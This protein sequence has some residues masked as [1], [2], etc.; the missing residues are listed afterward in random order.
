[1]TIRLEDIDTRD[2]IRKLNI[3]II[4]FQLI[5]SEITPALVMFA[6]P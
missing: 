4:N 5:F 2:S 3:M 1:M 6:L